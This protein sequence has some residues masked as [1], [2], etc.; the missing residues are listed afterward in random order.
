M[1][2]LWQVRVSNFHFNFCLEVR[3]A[4]GLNGL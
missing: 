1:E 4:I 3:D 2:E